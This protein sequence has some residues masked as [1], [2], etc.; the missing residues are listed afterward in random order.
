[1]GELASSQDAETQIGYY[2]DMIGT[3]LHKYRFNTGLYKSGS[4]EQ[5]HNKTE[6]YKELVNDSIYHA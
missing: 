5:L 3:Y 2:G 4:P 1:M 6:L